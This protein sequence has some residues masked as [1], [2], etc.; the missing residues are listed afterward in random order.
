MSLVTREA[1]NK[2]I[3][4][5]D[6][7]VNIEG[8]GDVRLVEM[9]FAEHSKLSLWMYP[10]GELDKERESLHG[11]RKVVQCVV[12]ENGK[13]VFDDFPNTKKGNLAFLEWARPIVAGGV[14]FWADLIYEVRKLHNEIK[15]DEEADDIK[16]K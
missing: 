8:L 10:D 6:Q 9:S 15:D 4:L 1:F 14:G 12:D 3:P 7:T 5:N 2:A 11:L 13:R 16:K